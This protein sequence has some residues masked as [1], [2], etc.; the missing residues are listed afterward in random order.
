MTRPKSPT[1]WS[2]NPPDDHHPLVFTPLAWLKWQYLCHAGPTEVA[3]FGLSADDD[4]LRVEDL[5]V[6]RQRATEATVAFD[7]A[8][9]ADLFDRMTDGGVAPA[10]FARIWLHT[11]PGASVVPS[12]PDESTFRR[13]FGSCDWA[14]MGIL[15]RTGRTSARLRFSAGPGGDLDLCVTV[16]W[17][18]WP[19]EADLLGEALLRW[20]ED[21]DLIEIAPPIALPFDLRDLFQE[22]LHAL[23]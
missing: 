19:L 21:L 5:L 10:R 8:A 2:S 16:D 4:P 12:G 9:V 18:V 1:S 14:I 3:A 22:N 13:A 20:Q 23:I 15:G 11:H 17:S 7:D 6:V